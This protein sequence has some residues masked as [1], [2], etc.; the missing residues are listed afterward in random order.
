MVLNCFL[1]SKAT[2][3]K[4]KALRHELLELLV[5]K[6]INATVIQQERKRKNQDYTAII[7]HAELWYGVPS[8][9]PQ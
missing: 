9:S 7:L 4:K 3:V 2:Y 8:Q 1:K 6:Q 5:L